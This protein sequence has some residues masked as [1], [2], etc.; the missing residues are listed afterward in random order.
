MTD[1]MWIGL[2]LALILTAP[3]ILLLSGVVPAVGG[4]IQQVGGAIQQVWHRLRSM[5][6]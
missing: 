2:G 1:G 5:V 6:V 3:G 4:A